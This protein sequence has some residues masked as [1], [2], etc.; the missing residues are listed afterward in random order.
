MRAQTPSLP[1]VLSLSSG[2]FSL[3]LPSPSLSLSHFLVPSFY[4]SLRA[5]A[6]PSLPYRILFSISLCLFPSL[7]HSYSLSFMFLF[8]NGFFC[9]LFILP[10][11]WVCLSNF[12]SWLSGLC[13]H[14]APDLDT[15]NQ[16]IGVAPFL[17]KIWWVPTILLAVTF[18]VTPWYAVQSYNTVTLSGPPVSL[19][20]CLWQTVLKDQELVLG[21]VTPRGICPQWS[22]QSEAH[23]L[24]APPHFIKQNGLSFFFFF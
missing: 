22:G 17:E 24:S 1:P 4:P 12:F 15:F 20:Y 6:F 5:I 23:R 10:I 8:Q 3:F 21:Y 11:Q 7:H 14:T 16:G 13:T 18:M 9:L 19:V 2:L